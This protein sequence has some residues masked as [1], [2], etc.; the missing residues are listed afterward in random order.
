VKWYLNGNALGE[1]SLNISSN[2]MRTY[3]YRTV[4]GKKGNWRTEIV[5]MSGVILHSAGFTVN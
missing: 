5:D 3:A 1:T 2:S 4:T